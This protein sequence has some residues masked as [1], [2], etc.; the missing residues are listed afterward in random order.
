MGQ[1]GHRTREEQ[2]MNAKHMAYIVGFIL[3]TA[4]LAWGAHKLGATPVWIGI[5]SVVLLGSG[6]MSSAKLAKSAPQN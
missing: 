1:R 2:H 3:M 5:G 4:G 6:I